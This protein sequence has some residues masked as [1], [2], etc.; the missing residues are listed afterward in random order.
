MIDNFSSLV[1]GHFDYQLEVRKIKPLYLNDIKCTL[2][3]LVRFCHLEAIERDVW[4][5][6]LQEYMRWVN[7]LKDLKQSEKSINK[8]LSHTRMLIDYAWQ[9]ERLDR[10]V[11]D[12]FQIKEPERTPIFESLSL[13]EA[14]GLMK[15][16]GKRTAIERRNRMITLLLYGCGFR[17]RELCSLDVTSIDMER[18][19]IKVVGKGSKE[20]MLPLSE[21]LFAELL[22]Y[23]T[24]RK[25]SRGPLFKTLVKS[26]RVGPTDLLYIVRLAA[27]RANIDRIITPKA[28]RHA[29]ASHLL[30]QGVDISTIAVLMGHRSPRETGVYIHAEMKDLRAAVFKMDDNKEEVI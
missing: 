11:L 13:D 5:L 12:G 7:Y 23:L 30:C 21:P 15:A 8:M 19:E 3:K 10:N 26:K 25:G 24:D 29:F 4:D 6:T 22:V 20:R 2:R 14:E 18:Q 16:F 28:L 9:L 27:K 1:Q 17:T